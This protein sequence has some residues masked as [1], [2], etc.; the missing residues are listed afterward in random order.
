MMTRW[1]LKIRIRMM[2]SHV[3]VFV[4][5]VLLL[6]ILYASAMF[7]GEVYV[8]SLPKASLGPFFTHFADG[9]LPIALIILLVTVPL[10]AVFSLITS[11]GL[12]SR[13]Q[14][15]VDATTH[16]V[17]GHYTQRVQVT[18]EDELGLLERQFNLIGEQLVESI[19]Q[20]RV[21]TE[22]N[23]R[24]AERT[25]ILRDLHDGVKQQAFALTMQ[26]S[27]ARALM[28]TQPE[29]A[30]IHLQN[31]EALAYQV[32]QELTALLQSSRPSVL[33]EKGLATALQQYAMTWSQ[34]QQIP[35]QQHIHAC[36]L[37]PLMEEALL[38]LAQEA[39]SNS[40]RHSHA[41]TVALD[42]SCKQD[43]VILIV[44]DNGCGFDPDDP[45]LAMKN[46]IGLQSMHERIEALGG[47]LRIESKHG[48][49][50]RVVASCPVA[51]KEVAE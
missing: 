47:T 32:Q 20:R 39:L 29:E 31:S 16:F 13:M 34:Q 33:S 15:L 18:S 51:D 40:A 23:T 28:E 49:G 19:E 1:Q 48:E 5:V 30:R 42:L 50:T 37:P 11:R 36:I 12:I 45:A 43:T 10:G 14:H 9:F 26:I 46:G 6:E 35:V 24:L 7:F 41:S 25:R 27:A 17:S 2:L 21:L 38:R 44:E 22:Q 4:A 3:S 8:H